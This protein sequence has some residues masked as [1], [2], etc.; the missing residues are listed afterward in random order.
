MFHF[1]SFRSEDQLADML[2]NTVSNKSF[3]GSINKLGIEDI[4]APT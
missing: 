4:F 2:T 1:F 3:H